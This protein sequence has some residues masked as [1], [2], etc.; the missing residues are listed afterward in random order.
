MTL[1]A[2]SAEGNDPGATTD[3][4]STV[5]SDFTTVIYNN[6]EI[7]GYTVTYTSTDAAGNAAIPVTRTVNIEALSSSND[8]VPDGTL[9]GAALVG[10]S[11]DGAEP[12]EEL[13][14]VNEVLTVDETFTSFD[15]DTTYLYNNAFSFH[16]WFKYT[17]D[18]ATNSETMFSFNQHLGS[19][20]SPP[21]HRSYW[22]QI[23]LLNGGSVARVQWTGN[24]NNPSKVIDLDLGT[25]LNDGNW[26]LLSLAVSYTSQTDTSVEAWLDNGSITGTGDL[27][28]TNGRAGSADIWGTK[29]KGLVL[30]GR[31]DGSTL[32]PQRFAGQLTQA[33]VSNSVIT[34]TDVQSVYANPPS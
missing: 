18:G 12:Q 17:G 4:G 2:G 6:S 19:S 28:G 23:P 15:T 16:V 3:D 1:T 21:S 34:L 26:H 29:T 31:Y 30:C 32:Q 22:V 25:S 24:A 13:S 8:E 9:I 20:T 33:T 5:T 11:L 27:A 10:S 14:Y 7:G